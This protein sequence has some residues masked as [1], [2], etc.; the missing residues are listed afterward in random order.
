MNQNSE[1]FFVVMIGY[2]RRMLAGKGDIYI[3]IYTDRWFIANNGCFNGTRAMHCASWK[4]SFRIH[5][6]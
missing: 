4:N 5:P 6:E 2:H 3:Y 1:A